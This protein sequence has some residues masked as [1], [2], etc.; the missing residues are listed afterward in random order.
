MTA[1]VQGQAPDFT[2]T[3]VYPGGELK[4]L[5]LSST[6]RSSQWVVLVF[7]SHAFSF[8]CPTEIIAHADKQVNEFDRYPCI[9]SLHIEKE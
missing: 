7:F 8:V 4:E 2:A 9:A 6:L 1:R 3:A 5:S